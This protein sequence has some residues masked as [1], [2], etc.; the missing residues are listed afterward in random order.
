MP[1]ERALGVQW[2]IETDSFEFKIQLQEK[3]LNRRGIL[4]MVSS[5]YDPLGTMAPVILPAKQILQELCSK[6]GW[7][8]RIP[9]RFQRAWFI[10]LKDLR[11]L[12]SY[13][14][15]RCLKPDGFG[16]LM[17]AQLHNFADASN[18]GYGTVSYLR[19]SN[20]YHQVHCA[21][22][23]G[24]ARV[25]PLKPITIPRMELMAAAV[26]VRMD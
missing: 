6:L 24:K 7:D 19:M 26:T 3:R 20:Q 4:S 18:S 16:P 13:K 10:W 21:F 2:C 5:I 22:L 8:E 14:L 25:A 17:S 23:I 9:E 15:R 11:L 1:V 12:E